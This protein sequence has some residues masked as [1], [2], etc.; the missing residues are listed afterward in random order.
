MTID[1]VGEFMG[2]DGVKA[3]CVWFDGMTQKSE[4]FSLT[5]LILDPDAIQP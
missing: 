3:R 5:S 1:K 4:V 2:H